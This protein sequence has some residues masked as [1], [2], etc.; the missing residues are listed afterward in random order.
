MRYSTFLK[1]A[2]II[3]KVKSNQRPE[4]EDDKIAYRHRNFLLK[5]YPQRV[6]IDLDLQ[7]IPHY[8]KFNPK[9]FFETRRETRIRR[10]KSIAWRLNWRRRQKKE[11]DKI[12]QEK[13]RYLGKGLDWRFGKINDKILFEGGTSGNF[14]VLLDRGLKQ[15]EVFII[16]SDNK[17]KI[18]DVIYGFLQILFVYYL[19]KYKL[20]ILI[21][22]SGIKDGN[23]GYLFAGPTQAGKTTASR[24]W[25]KLARIKVLNDDRIIIKKVNSQFYIYGT[26]W[27]GDFSDYLNTS[28][29]RAKLKKIFFIYHRERNKIARLSQR[30]TF[31]LFFQAIFCPFWDK[32][33]MN[34]VSEFLLDI[35]Y[36]ISCYKFGFKNDEKIINYVRNLE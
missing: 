17:W 24:I 3:I 13:E 16:N 33:G 27:H 31:N 26:P 11:A 8:T 36:S 30:E 6:D 1:I 9:V 21:H 18:S 35:I 2:D 32:D 22:S 25:D 15:G 5:K 23:N 34:F 4:K 7:T 29:Q 28:M 20:G 12:Q 19:P 10:K 14:Q